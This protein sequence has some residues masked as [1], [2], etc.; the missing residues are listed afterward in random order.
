MLHTL[1]SST[2]Q[3][4]PARLCPL[5]DFSSHLCEVFAGLALVLVAAGMEVARDCR[6]AQVQ[7]AILNKDVLEIVAPHGPGL[8]QDV[9]HLH[10]CGEGLVC[11]L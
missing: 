2:R 11:L 7:L 6:D 8:H 5:P 4:T 10:R 1:N 9:V 3:T